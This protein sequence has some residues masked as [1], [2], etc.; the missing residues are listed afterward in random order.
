MVNADSFYANFTNTTLQ[1]GPRYM[2]LTQIPSLTQ[3]STFVMKQIFEIIGHGVLS[4]QSHFS[5]LLELVTTEEFRIYILQSINLLF[6]H[7]WKRIPEWNNN[8]ISD[9]KSMKTNAVA[10][11]GKASKYRQTCCINEPK[12]MTAAAIT[13]ATLI[14]FRPSM[15]FLRCRFCKNKVV[16]FF[17]K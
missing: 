4:R 12:I 2:Y 6:E 11:I 1:K 17:E 16:E 14:R 3:T 10:W 8:L 13:Y 5:Y 7:I 15:W 9:S